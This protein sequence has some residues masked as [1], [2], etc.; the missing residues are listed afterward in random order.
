MSFSLGTP[1]RRS[2]FGVKVRALE[3]DLEKHAVDLLETDGWYA[4]KTELNYSFRKRK[5]TGVAGMQDHR[6]TRPAGG[7]LVE[8]LLVEF[9]REKG[10]KIGGRAEKLRIDQRGYHAYMRRLGFKT[11]IAGEDFVPTPEGFFNFYLASGLA[12]KVRK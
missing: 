4:E 3:A 2:K 11:L 1:I 6:F 12:R 8:Q 7:Y 9:K 5:S 10:G